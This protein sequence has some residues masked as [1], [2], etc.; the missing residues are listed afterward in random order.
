MKRESRPD[1]VFTTAYLSTVSH[2]VP[3]RRFRRRCCGHRAS[4]RSIRSMQ[5]CSQSP[6]L[7][8]ELLRIN[9]QSGGK[10]R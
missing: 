10:D 3:V 4:Y 1:L 7:E 8:A 2:P 5:G 6:Q 9:W